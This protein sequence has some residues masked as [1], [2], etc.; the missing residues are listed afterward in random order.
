[1]EEFLEDK[2]AHAN[3]DIM[4]LPTFEP[5]GL[6]YIGRLAAKT[7]TFVAGLTSPF[8]LLSP[9]IQ[10]RAQTLWFYDIAAADK[11]LDELTGYQFV[12]ISP[13]TKSLVRERVL[14]RAQERKLQLVSYDDHILISSKPLLSSND[15]VPSEN[16]ERHERPA[17]EKAEVPHK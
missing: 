2:A 14:K 9:E 5:D 3:Q 13:E 7:G 15:G 6:S 16:V 17:S 12:L 1:M 8:F 10:F 4:V 11:T